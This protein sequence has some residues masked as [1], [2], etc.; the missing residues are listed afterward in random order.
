MEDGRYA[1][2]LDG[3][4]RAVC[5]VCGT[6]GGV[7]ADERRLRGVLAGAEEDPAVDVHAAFREGLPCA[8]CGAISRDRCLILALG[9]I[10]GRPPPLCGWSAQPELRVFEGTA[11]RGHPRYMGELFDYFPAGYDPEALAAGTIDGRRH[12]DLQSLPYPDDFFDVLIS[13]EVLEHVRLHRPV[14]RE[15]HRTLRPGG[16]LLLQVPYVHEWPATSVL[17]HPH[18]DADVFLYPPLYHAEDTLVYRVYG[19]D[20]LSAL[21]AEGLSVVYT[22]LESVTHSVSPQSIILCRK[23]DYLDVSGLVAAGHAERRQ[24][25]HRER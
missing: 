17:V 8:G 12:A 1:A 25:L 7:G 16:L 2:I 5:N 23:G 6:A 19:R 9:G 10:L 20:L 4:G 15:M 3:L 21:A 24:R 22:E 14:L 13:S 18:G 11:Y